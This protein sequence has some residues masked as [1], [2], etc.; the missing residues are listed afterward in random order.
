MNIWPKPLLIVKE[1]I[2]VLHVQREGWDNWNV[3][4]FRW[5]NPNIHA[6]DELA[7]YHRST[8]LLPEFSLKLDHY[9][10]NIFFEFTNHHLNKK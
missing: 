2:D 8:F 9:F 1:E 7:W 3:E 10:N 4:F 5:M 6:F